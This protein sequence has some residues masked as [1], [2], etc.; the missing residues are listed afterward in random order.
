MSEFPKFTWLTD[1]NKFDFDP[2][3]LSQ[4][5][6]M[7][8]TDKDILDDIKRSLVTTGD[9][10]FA[11]ENQEFNF[12][13]S[14]EQSIWT[15]Y[16]I[17]RYK[18]KMYPIKKIVSDFPVYLLIEP[19]SVCN[20]RCTVCF[21]VDKSF[22]KKQFMGFM[23]ID[24]F[25]RLIDEA[26]TGGTQAVT[27]ASRGEPTLHPE[28][29]EMLT[30]ASGKFFDLKLNTNATKLSDS[31][32]RKIL[33]SGVNELVFSVDSHDKEIYESIRVGA[34]FD[35][36]FANIRQFCDIK[37]EEFPDSVIST[38][39]SGV[40]FRE[41]QDPD[42]FVSF[43]KEYVDDV[44]YVTVE[45]RWDTYNNPVR[46]DTDHPCEYLWERMY[47][48]HD[49]KCNPCDVD[50]KSVLSVGD[51]KNSSIREIWHSKRYSDLR[52]DH[53]NKLRTKN[54]PCDRC[55]I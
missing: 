37:R 29:E 49:G 23:N 38:R 24:L 10:P 53:L 51:A 2:D 5:D 15:K 32:I 54:V 19:T 26:V 31:L 41:D 40:K 46:T 11:V 52:D 12:M 7:S 42:A 34:K 43:W 14:H 3:Q 48:W 47:V 39:V 4:T 50:Y 30:Y 20:L 44:G 22:T 6:D 18:F 13:R 17:Y 45:N 21:Q 55:G 27:L 1:A 8:Q 9:F 35:Q 36:V 28:L 16:L 25:K 33:S